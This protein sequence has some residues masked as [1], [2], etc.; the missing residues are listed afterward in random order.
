MLDLDSTGTNDTEYYGQIHPMEHQKSQQSLLSSRETHLQQSWQGWPSLRDP[1]SAGI[2]IPPLPGHSPRPVGKEGSVHSTRSWGGSKELWGSTS[3]GLADNLSEPSVLSWSAIPGKEGG[4]DHCFW[5]VCAMPA[6]MGT[7]G[8]QSPTHLPV[9]YSQI[10]ARA[11]QGRL[12]LG[13]VYLCK[14]RTKKDG[15]VTHPTH[16]RAEDSSL[17]E[18][19]LYR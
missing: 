17:G 2:V 7:L 5:K 16:L 18:K 6:D 13:W 12:L 9:C 11:I 1:W 8:A 3:T 15:G 10:Y 4:P 14:G 19:P